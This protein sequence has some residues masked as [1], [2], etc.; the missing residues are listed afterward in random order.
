MHEA[1]HLGVVLDSLDEAPQ[2]RRS[3]RQQDQ[4]RR[5]QR[6]R[7]SGKRSIVLLVALLVV[8]GGL[9]GAYTA[10]KPWVT[11]LTASNDYTGQG[12]GS[13][14]VVVNPGDSGR[15]IGRSLEKAGVVKSADAFVEAAAQE[16]KAA[17]IQPGTYTLRSH[18]SAAAALQLMLDPSSRTSERVLV[19]EGLTA[20]QIAGVLSKASGQPLSE[21]TAALKNPEALGLPA[22]AKGKPEGWLFPDT[23]QFDTKSTAAEQLAAMVKQ[24]RSVLADL[25]VS[26]DQAQVVL[27]KASIVQAEGSR[28]QDFGKIARVIDNRLKQGIRLQMDSTVHYVV[29][30]EKVTTTKEQRQTKS[31]YNTYLVVGLPP[32]PIGSPGKAAIQAVL[33]PSP[34]DWLYF[35]AVNP[36]TGETK[37]AVTKAEH[38]RN[39]AEFQQWCRDNAGQC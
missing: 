22:A 39:V 31:P 34:G 12:T 6:R 18:M 21:Y 20:A 33:D 26:E 10:L 5:R 13:A 28:P 1:N 15:A 8:G 27:T 14:E 9:L 17:S 11:Q 35:V 16:P 25:G 23:Y 30:K 24:M 32:G 3:R 2:G 19:R 37:F 36:A 4:E 29:G 7:R 38:D